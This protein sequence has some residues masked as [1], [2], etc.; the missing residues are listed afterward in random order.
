MRCVPTHKSLLYSGQLI[1]ACAG[2]VVGGIIGALAHGQILKHK[3][4]K[5]KRDL[6]QNLQFHEEIY[7]RRDAQWRAKY[8]K[9]HQAYDDLEKETIERD[10]KEF[11]VQD[12]DFDDMVSRAELSTYLRKYLSTFPELTDLFAYFPPFED[13]DLNGDDIVSFEEWQQF[14]YQLKLKASNVSE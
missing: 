10:Y 4:A 12:T 3:S 14:T 6:I 13:F 5:E 2:V 11:K 7:K 9:L 8:S 1:I